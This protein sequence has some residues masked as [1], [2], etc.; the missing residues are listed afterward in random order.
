[1]GD[2]LRFLDLFDVDISLDNQ[3]GHHKIQDNIAIRSFG[4]SGFYI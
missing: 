3:P 2:I 1:M 4:R